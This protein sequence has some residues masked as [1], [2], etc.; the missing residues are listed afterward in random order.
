MKK[1][2]KL[3]V[4]LFLGCA[5]NANAQKMAHINSND[6][7][8]L[9]PERKQAETSIQE[10]A[11][12]MEGQMQ[13]LNQEYQSKVQDYQAKE[14]QMT[15]IIKKDKEKEI[16]DL[17]ERIKNF[18]QTAQEALQKKE[19]ELLSPMMEKAK[20]AITE[21]AK[22][23]GF[24]YVFDTATG[25]VLYSEPTEDILPLVKKKLGIDAAAIAPSQQKKA[26]ATPA[27]K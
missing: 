22:E 18:Q 11:K 23:G 14:A 4:A 10:Y 8:L 17:E 26:V 19:Q 9:M 1:A 24:K 13:T 5:L 20:K 15:D 7:M 27:G 6:L 21:V 2:F 16:I 25:V 12:Q 3:V